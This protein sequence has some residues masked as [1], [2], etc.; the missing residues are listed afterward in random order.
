MADERYM[1]CAGRIGPAFDTKSFEDLREVKVVM[2]SDDQRLGYRLLLPT[3]VSPEDLKMMTSFTIDELFAK[4][5]E[6]TNRR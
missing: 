2:V 4:L 3:D 5:S 6:T 1:L